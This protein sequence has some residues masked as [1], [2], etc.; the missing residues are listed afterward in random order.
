MSENLLLSSKKERKKKSIRISRKEIDFSE[1]FPI[2]FLEDRLIITKDGRVV[3]GYKVTLPE[4]EQLTTDAYDNLNFYFNQSIRVFPEG[5]NI[6]KTDVWYHDFFRADKSEAGF[7]RRKTIDFFTDR[8][9]LKHKSYLFVSFPNTKNV[10][11]LPSNTFFSLGKTLLKNPLDKIEDRIEQA[12]STAAQFVTGMASGSDLIRLERMEDDELMNVLYQYFNLE[13]SS[14]QD[15]LQR[16]FTN[17]MNGLAVGE[18]K[19]NILSLV[20]QGGKTSTYVPNKNG[21]S[22]PMLYPLT[23]DLH[24]PHMM[25]QTIGILNTEKELSKLDTSRKMIGSLGNYRNQENDVQSASLEM[26]TAEIRANDSRLVTLSLNA[27]VWDNDGALLKQKVDKCLSAFR[28]INGCR[29]V[30]ESFDTTNLFFS[31]C[32]GN[33]GQNYRLLLMPVEQAS[34]YV[35]WVTSRKSTEG[36]LVC[37]RYRQPV[38]LNLWDDRLDNKN[39]LVIGPSGSGKS[40]WT[41]NVIVQQFERGDDQI[42]IDVGG[43]YKNICETLGGEYHEYSIENPLS[44]NPFILPK[45]ANGFWHLDTDK[46]NFI[47]ALLGTIWKDGSR[48][49]SLSRQESA[50]LT[51]VITGYYAHLNSESV[52]AKG[53]KPS[54]TSFYTFLA[55]YAERN[56]AT[57]TFGKYIDVKSLLV[58]LEQFVT[59]KYK[60]VLNA[61]RE[62]DISE[63]QLICFD[64]VGIKSDPLLYPVISLLIIELVLDKLRKYPTKRKHI[65]MD[66]AWSM[67]SDGMGDFV[68][69][70]YRTIRKNNGAV[71][72]ITQGIDE[73]VKSTVGKAIISNAATKVLLDHRS[74][75]ALIPTL[76]TELGLTVHE[77]ELLKSI[78]AGKGWREFLVKLGDITKVYVLETAPQTDAAFSSKAEDRQRVKELT[79]AYNGNTEYALSQFVEERKVTSV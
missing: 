49:E 10:K 47:M 31:L 66:E 19:V 25:H 38:E 18:K 30:V 33:G 48:N 62:I 53:E 67:L 2:E 37:D 64:M 32:P 42:I 13:F 71:T 27:V 26:F 11:P 73:I 40:Y 79:Q 74:V 69:T 29:A 1:A 5:T 60:A 16:T 61:D 17:D 75:T 63:R 12:E 36:I 39:K 24:F 58:V 44:F 6:H 55:D 54:M 77:T 4:A 21:I 8:P 22:S 23:F 41:N 68:M 7:F 3:I 57:E 76:V 14:D 28:E 59:G 43:S 9:V 78:Q 70:M 72:I 20:N 56:Q 46:V 51:K 52:R 34:C 45:D 50:I 15:T 35:N 65:F